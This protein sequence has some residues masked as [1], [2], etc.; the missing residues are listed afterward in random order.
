MAA[1]CTPVCQVLPIIWPRMTRTRWRS[2]A[3]RSQAWRLPLP[4]G[5]DVR[6]PL[7][8]RFA[9]EELYGL[10]PADARKPYDV[11]EV[12]ARLVDD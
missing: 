7:P 4:H 12:I 9:A 11:R 3:V 10:I 8:P 5:L 1:T 2:R 6:E